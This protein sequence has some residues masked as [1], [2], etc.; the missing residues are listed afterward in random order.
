MMRR[1]GYIARRLG[2]A[3]LS[4]VS[5]FFNAACLGGSTSESVSA[6][7]YREPWP[8]AVRRINAALWIFE[9]DHCRKAWDTEVLDVIKTLER[10]DLLQK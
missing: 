8:R 5:R 4:A 6:R 2:H 3:L 7:A 10:N 9:R 1:A